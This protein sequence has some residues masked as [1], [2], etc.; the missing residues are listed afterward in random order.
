[1][2]STASASS[3]LEAAGALA[4]SLRDRLDTP[5]RLV[6]LMLD[7]RVLGAL[8]ML[9]PVP[10]G[11]EKR[12]DE[13]EAHTQPEGVLPREMLELL[14]E[15]REPS[16]TLRGLILEL[17]PSPLASGS[18]RPPLNRAL[19]WLSGGAVPIE[20]LA[21]AVDVEKKRI[22]TPF[23]RYLQ[24]PLERPYVG[25]V[26]ADYALVQA[27]NAAAAAKVDACAPSPLAPAAQI[28]P[29]SPIV[30]TDEPAP[31]RLA[32]SSAVLRAELELTRLVARARTLRLQSPGRAWPAELPETSSKAC[33]PRH[34]VTRVDA[35]R[36]E[37]RLAPNA[38]A[39]GEATVAFR[40]E[41]R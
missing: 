14:S 12:L 11:W 24:G 1:V 5:S 2:R 31:L 27:Q 26:A 13:I 37:I 19:V 41:A 4:A 21:V 18:E 38:F 39:E 9:D 28:A 29:W 36:A 16:C 33:A 3:A 7:R 35:G 6:A 22:A 23:Y 20:D 17:D 34:F 10:P 32:R 30:E 8:R 15:V 40:M 25:L